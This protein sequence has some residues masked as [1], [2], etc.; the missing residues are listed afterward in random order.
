MW[1]AGAG[2][3]DPG[4][5]TLLAAQALKTADVVVHDALVGAAVL[6]LAGPGAVLESVGKR[7]GRP[8]PTQDEI[9]KKL[10]ALAKQGKRVLR[11]KGGDP[12]L[13]GR[14]AEEAGALAEA[15]IPF[16]VVPGVTAGIGGLA[17]AGIPATA[18]DANAV[19]SFVTGHDETGAAPGVDWTALAKSSPVIV[20]Y[21]AMRKLDEI[22][23]NLMDAGRP[24]GEP[25]AVVAEAATPNQ[26]VLETT[27]SE[28]ARA[29]KDAGLG[30]PAVVVVGG[31]VPWRKVLDWWAP[32]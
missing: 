12:F 31:V 6:A 18:K 8:S 30:A 15:G 16:R 25:V 19:V 7:G 1:L 13:F 22:A 32:S 4:L 20:F 29:V 2:P 14:G 27:L 21:M 10:I 24:G 11:L 5:L 17:Y 26:R 9:S 3:G 23:S 28:C